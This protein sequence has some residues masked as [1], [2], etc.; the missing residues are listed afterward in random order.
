MKT[1]HNIPC[2]YRAAPRSRVLTSRLSGSG[3][4]APAGYQG[5][6]SWPPFV[7]KPGNTSVLGSSRCFSQCS[8]PEGLVEQIWDTSKLEFLPADLATVLDGVAKVARKGAGESMPLRD[9]LQQSP[10][11]YGSPLVWLAAFEQ[12]LGK[13]GVLLP[14][15]KVTLGVAI[16]RARSRLRQRSNA[17]ELQLVWRML[18]EAL[19]AT[20][21]NAE[22]FRLSRSAQGFMAIPLCSLV[23]GGRIQELFRLHVW[24]PDGQRG[25]PGFATH[26]HQP[27][28]QSWV[29]A[30]KGVD[31]SYSAES[32]TKPE[33]G[34]LAIYT[35]GWADSKEVASVY[36]THQSFSKVV[37]THRYIRPKLVRTSVHS[38]NMSYT[39]PAGDFH[40]TEVAGDRLHA[41]LFFFDASRGFVNDAPVLGPADQESS[42]QVRE[43]DVHSPASL[44]VAVHALRCWEVLV[45][46]SAENEQNADSEASQ[47]ALMKAL[48]VCHESPILSK[49]PYYRSK[50]LGDLSRVYR[51]TGEYA[52]DGAKNFMIQAL[53]RQLLMSGAHADVDVELQRRLSEAVLRMRY[54]EMFQRTI[55]P[56]LTARP[57]RSVRDIRVAYD[58]ALDLEKDKRLTFD[59][60]KYVRYA[61]MV[62]FGRFPR[63]GDGII[64]EYSA[65][66]AVQHIV[67]ISYRWTT[68]D[69]WGKTPDNDERRLYRKTMA[70]IHEFLES[71]GEVDADALGIWIDVCC[72]DQDNPLQGVASLPLMVPQCDALIS[73]VDEEYHDRAWCS[74]EVMIIHALGH[75]YGIHLWFQHTEQTEEGNGGAQQATKYRLQE[76]PARTEGDLPSKKLRFPHDMDRVLFLERQIRLMC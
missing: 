35:V 28:A 6:P 72:I 60:L 24:L 46:Q 12:D 5:Y 75:A 54:R 17:S 69:P 34:D 26:S 45:E 48:Q 9:Y 10:V 73:L 8:G 16:L 19:T 56:V 58:R 44:A 25:A 68:R 67:F 11:H 52:K 1:L 18:Y 37:N 43:V 13:D 15:A 22:I 7:S 32:V 41:T 21:E 3:F 63:S 20:G 14:L 71:R 53:E 57:A 65:C 31:H 76:G 39:I 38:A 59:R 55:R 29:L 23:E 74:V 2:L 40:R 70:A 36:K 51:C 49:V 42:V 62:T 61:D 4:T 30:G 27:H 47:R 64:E 33:A 50:V 66:S